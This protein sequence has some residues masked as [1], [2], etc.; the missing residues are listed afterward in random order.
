MTSEELNKFKVG[1]KVRVE[2]KIP[3]F[4]KKIG[5]VIESD[6]TYPFDLDIFI[7]FPEPIGIQ[8]FF[9][10]KSLKILNSLKNICFDI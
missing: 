7:K 8:A 5:V 4:Y 6:K 1:M 10:A 9:Y 3:E 2:C